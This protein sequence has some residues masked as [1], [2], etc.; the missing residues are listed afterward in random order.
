MLSITVD[1]WIETI[2]T[3]LKT[4]LPYSILKLPWV[5]RI[6]QQLVHVYQEVLQQ[7]N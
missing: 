6:L 4:N 3:T 5:L 2:Q 1:K 7:N